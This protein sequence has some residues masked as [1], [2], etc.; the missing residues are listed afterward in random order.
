MKHLLFIKFLIALVATVLAVQESDSY[1]TP[2]IRTSGI[3]QND[4]TTVS[5]TVAPT[6]SSA[7][8]TQPDTTTPEHPVTSTTPVTTVAPKPPVPEDGVWLITDGNTTCI[9]AILKIR[10]KIP[11]MFGQ[12]EYIL[13]SP[14]ASS[15][16]SRCDL[17]NTTQELVLTDA[18]YIFR[19]VFK[20]DSVKNA[21]VQNITLSY[22]LPEQSDTV[23]NDSKLFAVKVGNSY[24]CRSM[25]DVSL[26]NNVT[27]Q[28]FNIHLQA[29]GEQGNA[30]FGPAEQCEADDEVSDV[31][32]I[33]V[34]CALCAL[35]VIVL[36]AYLV[37]R[38]RSRQRGYQSV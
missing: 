31:I 5:S 12:D 38:Q 35:I 19:M 11:L 27:M 29:F 3:S 6:T 28:I 36:I 26:A 17:S 16:R 14:N 2:E 25:E 24:R 4:I 15:D 30:D 13:L 23:Y 34:A 37:A 18:N 1:T 9:R 32:P 20:E 22:T 8:T 7:P 10:F 21:F 33:A